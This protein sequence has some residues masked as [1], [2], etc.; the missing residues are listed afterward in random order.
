MKRIAYT[1]VLNGLNHLT[2][3]NFYFEMSK[4]FDYWV[5]VEGVSAPGG[6]TSW[7][8]SVEESFHNNYLSKDGTTEFLTNNVLPNVIVRKCENEPWSSKDEQVNHAIDVIKQEIKI[9]KCFLWQVDV[10][11]QWKLEDLKSAEN[12]LL[13]HNG[14]TGC[15]TCNYFVGRNQQ[16]IGEWGENKSEPYRRLWLW[17]GEY[18]LVHEPPTLKGKNGPGLL[19]PERFNHYA[20]Y[21]EEDVKFKEKYYGGYKGL[22][23]RWLDIQNNKGTIPVIKLLGPNIRWSFTNTYIKY[24]DA[25]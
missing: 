14:K 9:D 13:K 23:E 18:F 2:H 5:I 20:Y 12:R 17:E 24:N 15:F 25:C 19:L 8:N 7:C 10:D 16:V 11:E 3:N 1:I 4:M 6:S 21:F 22:Y